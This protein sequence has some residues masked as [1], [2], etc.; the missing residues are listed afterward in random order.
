MRVQY[1]PLAFLALIL[2][3]GVSAKSKIPDD[4]TIQTHFFNMGDPERPEMVE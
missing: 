2:I 3:V 4:A 1:L